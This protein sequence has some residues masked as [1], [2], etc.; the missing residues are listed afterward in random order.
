MNPTRSLKWFPNN[1][2][3][4]AAAVVRLRATL[5]GAAI[6][7]LWT[8]AGACASAA[9]RDAV[10]CLQGDCENGDG[11]YVWPGGG[12]YAGTFQNR[13][14]HGRG[15]MIYGSGATCEGEWTAGKLDGVAAC[16]FP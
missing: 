4:R 9:P 15:A 3:R 11:V 10:G 1:T 5:S 7:A 6:L 13:T 2:R 12:R 16:S 14:P 8:C